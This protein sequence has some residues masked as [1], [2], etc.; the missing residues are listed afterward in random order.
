MVTLG[1][2]KYMM[3]QKKQS[4]MHNSSPVNITDKK[5]NGENEGDWRETKQR[6]VNQ[7]GILN[8]RDPGMETRVRVRLLAIRTR[9][10]PWRDFTHPCWKHDLRRAG[11][12]AVAW[13]TTD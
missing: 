3:L 11:V 9:R 13:T 8:H 10:W 12:I 7:E 1:V 4:W 6:I 2:D 5:R